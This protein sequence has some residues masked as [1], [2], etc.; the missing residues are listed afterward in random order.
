M[1]ILSGPYGDLQHGVHHSGTTVLSERAVAGS[2]SRL[3]RRP[4]HYTWHRYSRVT[5]LTIVVGLRVSVSL[6]VFAPR[7]S[8]S[9]ARTIVCSGI[10][11]RVVSAVILMTVVANDFSAVKCSQRGFLKRVSRKCLAVMRQK[12]TI[13]NKVFDICYLHGV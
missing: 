6:P 11:T 8:A 5:I 7:T 13:N 10:V 3:S 9:L 2:D 12:I 4:R 1:G